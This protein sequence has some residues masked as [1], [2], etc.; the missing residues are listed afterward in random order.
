MNTVNAAYDFNYAP[1][2]TAYKNME[3]PFEF[4][5]NGSI[6]LETV[7]FGEDDGIVLRMYE[8]LGATS[9]ASLA[10]KGKSFV[11]CN[12]LEDEVLDLGENLVELEFAPFEI[13]TIK[14]K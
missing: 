5:S 4:S 6:V 11:E 8:A 1:V 10:S 12:I 3:L 2:H 7:K 13:K 9:K 14:I